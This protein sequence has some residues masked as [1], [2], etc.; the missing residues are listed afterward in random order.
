MKAALAFTTLTLAALTTAAPQGFYG[1]PTA[2]LQ[3]EVAPDTFIS[4]IVVT[5]GTV[6]EIDIMVISATIASVSGV[7]NQDA[8]TCVGIDQSTQIGQPFSLLNTTV[9]NNGNLQEITQFD[10]Q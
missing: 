5:L 3:L 8:V 7:A 6:F 9:F 10:C 2:T 1:L 4:D